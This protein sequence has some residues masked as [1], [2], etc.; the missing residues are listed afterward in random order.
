[1]RFA[2]RRVSHE[3]PTASMADVTFLLIIFFLVTNSFSAVRG[4]DF[5]LAQ[6]ERA[7]TIDR[8][9]SVVV[10]IDRAGAVAVDGR[11]VRLEQLVGTLRARLS[12]DEST[13]V[14][15]RPEPDAAY[16]DVLAV[17]DAL[18]RG[19]DVGVEVNHIVIPTQREIDQ[20]WH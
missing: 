13:P 17:Y 9:A 18:R 19:R 5:G 11:P 15:L 7:T 4:L 3:I 12:A 1:M 8:E 10:T 6:R 14:I 16:G 2:T 20:F